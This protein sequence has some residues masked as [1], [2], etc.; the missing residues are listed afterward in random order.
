[1]RAKLFALIAF[2]AG[3]VAVGCGPA[4]TTGNKSTTKA[5][6]PKK[7]EPKKEEEKKAEEPKKEEPKK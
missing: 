1:M 5:T 2:V 6:E 4:P 7:E 3:L